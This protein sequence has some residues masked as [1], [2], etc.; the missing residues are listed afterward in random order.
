[1]RAVGEISWRDE[2]TTRKMS[3]VLE[4]HDESSWREKA[5]GG[6]EKNAVTVHVIAATICSLSRS[7][8]K[9]SLSQLR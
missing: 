2:S 8:A 4:R 9:L 6:R 7:Y 1:M 3:A 5:V